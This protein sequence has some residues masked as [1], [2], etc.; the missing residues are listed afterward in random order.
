M[1]N[2]LVDIDFVEK[3]DPSCAINYQKLFQSRLF[4][5]CFGVEKQNFIT[6][7]IDKKNLEAVANEKLQELKDSFQEMKKNSLIFTWEILIIFINVK[8]KL[9]NK[10]Y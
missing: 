3:K 8:G 4:E 6:G 10:I 1:F 5:A 2:F 7:E 9:K